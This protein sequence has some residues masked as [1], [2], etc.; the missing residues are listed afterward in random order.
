MSSDPGAP[1]GRPTAGT[2]ILGLG[3]PLRGDDGVGVAVIAA[4]RTAGLPAG[5]D[6]LDGG[7]PGLEIVLLL[8][9]YRRA[10]IVDAADV[11]REPG[12]WLRFTREEVVLGSG[13]L[14]QMG[15]VHTAGL[16]EAL[17]LGEALRVLPEEIVLYGVQ[18]L[19]VGWEP[20]LSDAVAAAVPAVCA[21]VQAEVARGAG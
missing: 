13:D 4:L 3:N 16:A 12:E 10:V 6:L 19:E 8:Q 21:A 11:G 2:L 9:G 20:G 18:P 5:V 17:R 1:G 15:A 7:T 14:G